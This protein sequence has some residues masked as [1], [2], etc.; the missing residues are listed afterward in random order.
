MGRAEG[1]GWEPKETKRLSEFRRKLRAGELDGDWL[2]GRDKRYRG[3]RPK[4]E[5]VGTRMGEGVG[6]CLGEALGRRW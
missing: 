1:L 6:G 2:I 3:F 4:G 5:A